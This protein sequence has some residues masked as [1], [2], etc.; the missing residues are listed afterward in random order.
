RNSGFDD[1]DAAL[2]KLPAGVVGVIR[3][4]QNS[5]D[6]GFTV[7]NVRGSGDAYSIDVTTGKLERW[8][9]SESAVKTDAFPEAEIVKWNSFDG[10]EISSFL[11]RPP[12][13]RYP[14]KRPVLA[15]IHGGTEGQSQPVFLRRGNN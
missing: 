8:T 6:L 7:T 10:K 13:A 1:K 4:H 2:P 3:W 14:V 9:T 11:D 15:V 12:A 5:R